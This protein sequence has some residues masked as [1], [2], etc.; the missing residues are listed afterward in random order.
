MAVLEKRGFLMNEIN[1]EYTVIMALQDYMPV[2]ASSVGLFILARGIA[3]VNAQVSRL[4]YLGWI[5][6]TIGG[7]SKATWKLVMAASSSQTNLIALDDA[8]F[9]FMGSGFLFMGFALWYAQRAIQEKAMPYFKNVYVVPFTIAAVICG[10]S[11][12]MHIVSP[13]TRI[14][15][16][17]V[18][19]LTTVSNFVMLGLL[20]RL[21]LQQKSVL[22]AALFAVNL[23]L[24]IAMTGMARVEP[25]TIPLEWTAQITNTISNGAFAFGCYRL[26]ILIA[27]RVAG[28]V[29]AP[30]AMPQVAAS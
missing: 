24:I 22:C 29:K 23:V 30:Q 10:L 12:V 3:T 14:W 27:D 6:V 21:S 28:R 2:I 7:F 25:Q 11:L 19:G 15:Y 8:M 4:A 18:L 20:I 1:N 9:F 13:N 16:Y 5:L 17:I 26:A